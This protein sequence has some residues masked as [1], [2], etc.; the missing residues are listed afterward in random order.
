MKVNSIISALLSTFALVSCG[1]GGSNGA[2][3]NSS[4]N[5]GGSSQNTGGGTSA[6][7]SSLSDQEIRHLV[8]V[9]N[10][11][12]GSTGP[13][14]TIRWTGIG[15]AAPI[16]SVYIPTPANSTEVELATKTRTAIADINRKTSGRIALT[17]TNT[18]PSSGGYIR[19]SYLT[20]YVPQN[21]TSSTYA[22]YCANVSTGPYLPNIITPDYSTGTFNNVVAYVNLGNGYC[23]V[24]QDI[25]THEVGHALGL[26]GH[27]EGFGNGD[28][29]S[30][31]FW[32]VLTTIYSNPVGT[33]FSTLTINRSVP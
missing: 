30:P 11:P 9:S 14:Q 3:N 26:Y 18:Q 32:D 5:T 6:G 29:I 33:P 27:F 24:V 16:V 10:F 12:F 23:N 31:D 7:A 17:E 21:P 19:V 25:V 4:T 28:A 22:S 15:N 1:G 8:A 20:S 2:D 13:N